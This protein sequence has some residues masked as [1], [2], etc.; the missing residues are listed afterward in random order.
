MADAYECG[1]C[2]TVESSHIDY[3]AGICIRSQRNRIGVVSGDW[4]YLLDAPAMFSM[5]RDELYEAEAS[6]PRVVVN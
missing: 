4:L 6:P 1:L 3:A 2:P 5:E